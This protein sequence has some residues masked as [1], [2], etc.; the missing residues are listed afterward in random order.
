MFVLLHLHAA[1]IDELERTQASH[2]LIHT[3]ILCKK[4][5]RKGVSSQLSA[6]MSTLCCKTKGFL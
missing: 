2:L 1:V 6:P 3:Q 4:R 5:K